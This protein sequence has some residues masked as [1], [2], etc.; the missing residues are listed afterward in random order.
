MT[1]AP[2][3]LD[4]IYVTASAR[5]ARYTRLCVASIRHFYPDAPVKLLAGGPL[6]PGL[7]EELARYWNVAM[8]DT[9]RGDWGW[10]FVK[11]EPLFGPPGE[12]FL[13]LDSDTAFGGRVLETWADSAADFLVDDEQQSE[14]DIC[15]LYYDWRKVAEIDPAARPPQFVF[16][17]GQWFGTAGV[18]AREDFALFV[19]WSRTPPRLRRPDLFMPG[20][21]GVLNYL[22]NQKAAIDGL[23][24]ERRKI[25]RWPGHGMDGFSAASVAGRTAPPLVIHWAGMKRP[26]LGAMVGADVLRFLERLYHSRLPKSGVRRFLVGVRYPLNDWRHDLTQRIRQ[27]LGAK[28][29]G[30]AAGETLADEDR[31]RSAA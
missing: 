7:A 16:N 29:R 8:A 30:P 27:R 28:A 26:R 3:R 23:S 22:L 15:R 24:V 17:S 19:D 14:A 20:D 4:C 21:Q 31:E 13:V 10:G 25:M 2:S 11:L 9:P 5:D 1:S 6:E 18:L 12:R